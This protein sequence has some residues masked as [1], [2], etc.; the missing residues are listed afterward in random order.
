MLDF[1]L[2]EICFYLSA[3]GGGM[4]GRIGAAVTGPSAKKRKDLVLK[5]ELDDRGKTLF[6]NA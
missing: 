5:T 4:I 6:I 1:P 2:E 3:A